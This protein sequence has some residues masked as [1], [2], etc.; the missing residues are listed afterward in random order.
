M[1]KNKIN[2]QALII[3]GDLGLVAQGVNGY[4]SFN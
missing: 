1:D 4:T 2:N 3:L